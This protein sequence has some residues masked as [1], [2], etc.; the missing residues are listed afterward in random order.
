M[1]EH[2]WTCSTDPVLTYYCCGNPMQY[3]YIQ[4]ELSI[5]NVKEVYKSYC[6]SVWENAT[7]VFVLSMTGALSQTF[8]TLGIN[9]IRLKG[10]VLHWATKLNVAEMWDMVVGC[11]LCGAEIAHHCKVM[12]APSYIFPYLSLRIVPFD[13]YSPISLVWCAYANI[14]AAEYFFLGQLFC[15]TPPSF[16]PVWPENYWRKALDMFCLRSLDVRML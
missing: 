8:D 6:T 15:V 9:P 7:L 3:Q 11:E 10:Q 13:I 14:C 12:D 5:W 1:S 16:D 2:V 4:A